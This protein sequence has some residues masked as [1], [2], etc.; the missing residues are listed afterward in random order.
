MNEC[1]YVCM[2]GAVARSVAQQ[3]QHVRTCTTLH[4]QGTFTSSPPV[5]RV[6]CGMCRP[7]CVSVRIPSCLGVHCFP[8]AGWLSAAT[9]RA[10]QRTTWRICS[11]DVTFM[12]MLKATPAA[13]GA[14]LQRIVSGVPLESAVRLC[15]S[16]GDVEALRFL[17]VDNHV[18][19][20]T[21]AEIYVGH[22]DVGHQEKT[23][24]RVLPLSHDRVYLL[25]EGGNAAS[26]LRDRVRGRRCAEKNLAGFPV[27]RNS[28]ISLSFP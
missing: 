13:F 14:A 25:S 6:R 26:G 1:M 16:T 17:G 12:I 10:V 11:P 8:L 22:H 3:R 2:L 9:F 28:T 7:D 21:A 27:A 19:D 24:S 20:A 4:T 15:S 23:V 18:P 5:V